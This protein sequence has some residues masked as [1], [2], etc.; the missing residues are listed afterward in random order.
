MGTK[1]RET[2]RS[3]DRWDIE[4][5]RPAACAL[6]APGAERR[7]PHWERPLLHPLPW[8][9]TSLRRVALCAARRLMA[10]RCWVADAA[11][12]AMTSMRRCLLR[13]TAAE[14]GGWRAQGH[15]SSSSDGCRWERPGASRTKASVGKGQSSIS[16]A[17]D[18]AQPRT[19]PE[20]PQV[21]PPGRPAFGTT[22]ASL[23]HLSRP[24][25]PSSEARLG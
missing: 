18:I 11:A 21:S 25:S 10:R 19:R 7:P 14:K 12:R 5:R 1:E 17:M 8:M 9:R 22:R 20:P 15:T 16:G 6:R 4:A 3:E 24:P 2:T 13:G 23:V